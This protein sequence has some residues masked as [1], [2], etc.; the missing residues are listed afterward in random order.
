MK[1]IKKI[2]F[3]DLQHLYLQFFEEN[4]L[5]PTKE[6]GKSIPLDMNCHDMGIENKW[7]K[8]VVFLSKT[9]LIIGY[10]RGT[11]Q[12]FT[13]NCSIH[14]LYLKDCKDKLLTDKF[15][16]WDKLPELTAFVAHL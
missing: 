13:L 11:D 4:G 12:Q 5:I 6:N 15:I 16:Y 10:Y 8:D 14:D 3:K 1:K 2:K 7:S 9:G